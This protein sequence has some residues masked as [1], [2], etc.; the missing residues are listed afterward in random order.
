MNA[1]VSAKR[2]FTGICLLS[3]LLFSGCTKDLEEEVFSFVAV[4]NFWKTA[5]DADAGVKGIYASF[6]TG[7]YLNSQYWAVLEQPSDFTTINRNDTHQQL[8]RWDL[9]P[10]HPFVTDLWNQMYQ[11]IARA[12][13]VITNV[14]GISMPEA[15][16][17]AIL[18]EAKFLRAFVYFHIVRMWG[19]APLSLSVVENVA[20]TSLPRS[21]VA[22]LYTQIEKDLTEAE[23]ELPAVRSGAETGRITSGAAKTLL[24]Y[25]YLT[26][27]KWQPAADKAREV[28]T[29]NRYAL[30]ARFGDVFSV[31]NKN[32]SEVIFAVQYDG[33]IRGS[34]LSS[35]ANIGGANSPYAANG[36]L[37]WS[38]DPKS[39]IWTKWDVTEDRRNYSVYSSVVGRN[40][41][42]INAD[43]NFPSYGKWRDPTEPNQ[44]SSKVNPTLLRYADVLLIFA[45]A[46]AQA[47]GGPTAETYEALNQIIRRAYALPVNTSS[48]RDVSGLSL[49]AFVDKVIEERGFEFTLEAKRLFDLM[50]TDKFPA[51]IKELGKPAIR[52]S[53]FPIPQ[54]EIDAS[55]AISNAD[56]NPG[57]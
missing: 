17:K 15:T 25:V 11:Q 2:L 16:K 53:L 39:D 56:Q 44:N 4:P 52:G 29:S 51:K 26:Q 14:P 10:N 1:I 32:N 33:S 31:G 22:A 40:G 36:A 55:D 27:K 21:P 45:E 34:N 5:A 18:G 57:Y 9:P 46:E 30:Q 8:D 3:G 37:V 47:K 50:R 13:G 12:N 7:Q 35:F 48:S 6:Y 23:T 43:P 28:M 38:V 42:T 19:A 41:N 54:S 49:A 20:S 24:A